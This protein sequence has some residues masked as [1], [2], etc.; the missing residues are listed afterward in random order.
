M[1]LDANR[2]ERLLGEDRQLLLQLAEGVVVAAATP[3][4]EWA[5]AEA[6]LRLTEHLTDHVAAQRQLM[7][8]LSY[9]PTEPHAAAHDRLLHELSDVLPGHDQ[10]FG[11]DA[12]ERAQAFE[13][14]MQQ[15]INTWDWNLLDYVKKVAQHGEGPS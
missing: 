2:R 5:L 11:E 9:P 13:W 8:D 15:H 3:G 7:H 10:G 14:A 6:I 4:A 1:T 12:L